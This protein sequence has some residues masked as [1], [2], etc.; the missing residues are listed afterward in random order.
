MRDSDW[1]VFLWCVRAEPTVITTRAAQVDVTVG[2][3]IVLPCQVSHDPSLDVKF[4]WFFNE[5]VI[6]FGS[7]GGYFE[8]VGGVSDDFEAK[9]LHNKIRE[10]LS[11]KAAIRFHSSKIA[12][13]LRSRTVCRL[14]LNM[15]HRKSISI[16]WSASYYKVSI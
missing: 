4:T 9:Y 2:E 8:K 12:N 5:L 6:Q 13:V 3:S 1:C 10:W 7:H 15:F 14:T 16:L 11:T